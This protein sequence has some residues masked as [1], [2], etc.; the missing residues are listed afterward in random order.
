MIRLLTTFKPFVGA[1]AEHQRTAIRSWREFSKAEIV[2]LGDREEGARET[3]A[4]F[5]ARN[6]PTADY[7][8]AD[9]LGLGYT[10]PLLNSIVWW[11]DKLSEPGDVVGWIN[12]DII[13][14]RPADE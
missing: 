10:A 12:A 5:G 6:V 13:F 4:E 11:A 9:D 3:C 14:T 1:P 7:M 8:T 2:V